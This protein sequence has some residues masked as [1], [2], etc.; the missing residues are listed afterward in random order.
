NLTLGA[1][2]SLAIVL[3][4]QSGQLSGYRRLLAE[5][6]RL[7]RRQHQRVSHRG[8]AMGTGAWV[9]LGAR[10]AP[11][12]P[13]LDGSPCLNHLSMSRP[14]LFFNPTVSYYWPNGLA[15]N[16]GQAGGSFLAVKSSQ[17]KPSCKR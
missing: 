1:L 13:R 4:L 3:P 16:L 7:L 5:R 12:C 9:S 15:I 8:P 10:R 6:A 17:A 11:V 14:R 2:W